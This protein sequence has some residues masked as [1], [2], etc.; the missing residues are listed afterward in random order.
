MELDGQVTDSKY[1]IG[2]NPHHVG[3]FFT[4]NSCLGRIFPKQ[5]PNAFRSAKK[6]PNL[7]ER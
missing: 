7:K 2:L 1:V 5:A 4:Q 6:N 3:S